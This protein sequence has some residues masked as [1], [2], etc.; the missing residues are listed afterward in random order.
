MATMLKRKQLLVALF[1]ETACSLYTH[2][3]AAVRFAALNWFSALLPRCQHWTA[4]ASSRSS[5]LRTSVQLLT[6]RLQYATL[7]WH[8]L[9]TAT[10]PSASESLQV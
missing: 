4:S 9:P 1:E 10:G 5:A 8:C 7:S 2:V 3:T 6:Q